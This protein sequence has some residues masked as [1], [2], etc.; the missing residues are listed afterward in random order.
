MNDNFHAIKKIISE[1][2]GVAQNLISKESVLT[3]DF[4]LSIIEITDLI[5]LIAQKFHLQIPDD[6]SI[7]S[8]NTVEDLLLMIE[9]LSDEY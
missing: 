8:I 6:F 1:K 2:F 7:S 5:G 3:S 9:Q 4:N